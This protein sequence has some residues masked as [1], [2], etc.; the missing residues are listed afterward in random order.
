LSE[1]VFSNLT[2]PTG[3]RQALWNKFETRIEA[4]TARELAAINTFLGVL[5][6]IEPHLPEPENVLDY[7]ENL[8]EE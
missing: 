7:W 8:A 4:F 5:I 1:A 2:P 3:K 6:E